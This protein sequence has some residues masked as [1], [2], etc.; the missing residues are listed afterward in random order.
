[1][2]SLLEHI[3]TPEQ[4]IEVAPRL[5]ELS[6]RGTIADFG[7]L[8]RL[9][10]LFHELGSRPYGV[11]VHAVM[12]A[13]ANVLLKQP[14]FRMRLLEDHA[15]FVQDIQARVANE[16]LTLEYQTPLWRV[17]FLLAHGSTQPGFKEQFRRGIAPRRFLELVEELPLADPA[18]LA[19]VLEELGKYWY[20]LCYNYGSLVVVN[21][22]RFW[23]ALEK[24][25]VTLSEKPTLLLPYKRALLQLCSLLLLF[26][27]SELASS[28]SMVKNLMLMVRMQVSSWL[29]EVETELYSSPHDFKIPQIL[30]VLELYVLKAPSSVR[31]RIA[32]CI[33]SD[34]GCAVELKTE[35]LALMG[36][37]IVS[38]H[39]REA[40][41]SILRTLELRY[42]QDSN[43]GSADIIRIQTV[44]PTTQASPSTL[45]PYLQTRKSCDTFVPVEDNESSA[46][47]QSSATRINPISTNIDDDDED[48][49]EDEKAA[50][51]DRIFTVLKRLNELGVVKTEGLPPIS[52]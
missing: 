34:P 36:S 2:D 18:M 16:P 15:P 49:T 40:L 13:I 32:C 30:H 6:R 11:H 12:V 51:T 8:K 38:S 43:T 1:M 25:S 42:V 17:L 22:P 29:Q 46:S 23:Q 21:A 41:A 14:A 4:L 9:C 24:L 20:A 33:C 27:E 5:R 37:S 26:P 47:T 52:N 48:W 39:M 7:S 45:R 19:P 50:E 28:F 10:S 31:C 35:T 3:E 44:V